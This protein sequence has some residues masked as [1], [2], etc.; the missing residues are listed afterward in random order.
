M[1]DP[2]KIYTEAELAKMYDDEL[3]EIEARLEREK[4]LHVDISKEQEEMLKTV[5]KIRS[6]YD[7]SGRSLEKN[8]TWLDRTNSRLRG[9]SEIL[10]GVE[11]LIA[12]TFRI[13]SKLGEP[14][15]KADQAAY[16][17]G[18][19][20]GASSKAVEQLRD[21]TIKFGAAAHIG[22]NYNATIAEMINLQES[23]AKQVGRN[24]QL[25][26]T[27][28]ETL[29]ATSKIMGDKAIDFSKK[30]ENLGIG[31]ER[32]G[33][34]AAKMFN[35]ASK[36]GV[37][38]EKYSESVTANLTKVQSYGFRNGVEGLTAMA[39]K[40]AEVNLN[41]AEAFK[42]ADKIQTGGI[43]EAIKMGANL[44]VLGG[45]FA[46]MGDPM[47]MLYQGLNDVEGL[48]DRMVKMFSRLG[49]I[50][51]GQVKISAANRLRVN[52][53]AQAM[54]IS[55]DE[56]FNMISRQAVRGQV[57]KQMGGR[58]DNDEE[59]KEL[60]M[61]TA[62][63][64]KNNEA[65]VNINGQEKKLSEVSEKDKAYLKDL[66]KSES[67]DIKDIAQILRGYT[68][69]QSG[70]TK[71]VE[72]QKAQSFDFI[73]KGT[74]AIYQAI[75]TS[76]GFLKA[77]MVS[78]GILT[79][80]SAVSN[81]AGSIRNIGRGFGGLTGAGRAA[82]GTAG[83]TRAAS[84]TRSAKAADVI[85]HTRAE[86]V[87]AAK[88]LESRGYT[89]KNGKVFRPDGNLA[90]GNVANGMKVDPAKVLAREEAMVAKTTKAA[91]SATK[92]AETA[93]KTAGAVT[94]AGSAV[95]KAASVGG[96]VISKAGGAIAGGAFAALGYAL[97]GSW[98]GSRSNKNKAIGGTVGATIGGLASMIPV[99]GPIAGIAGAMAG[100]WVGEKIGGAITKMQD[101]KRAE[102]RR[103]GL[104]E[105]GKTT[106]EG[107]AFEALK[108]DYSS[109]ELKKIK[110]A[111]KDGTIEKGELSKSL[112][113]KLQKS[114]D[115]DL[116]ERFG[117]EEAKNKFK[118]AI[119]KMN[120]DIENG[121]MN[122]KNANVSFAN[123]NI[124]QSEPIAMASGGKLSGPSDINGPGMPIKGSNIVVGGGEYIVNAEATKKNEHLLDRINS[125]ETIK[126]AGGGILPKIN[127]IV[128][129]IM[130][131][132][133]APLSVSVA[134][135]ES[136]LGMHRD[137]VD[138]MEISPIKLDVSGTIKLDAG[139]KQVDLD[140]IMNNPAFLTQLSQMIERRLSDNI[141][142]GNFKELRKSK[143]HNF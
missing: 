54:G 58:F 70:F 142:G 105:L 22:E 65:V 72:N 7:K 106:D 103:T 120:A 108:G 90:R 115:E 23:Y 109:K 31:L 92:A 98:K 128:P 9:T 35:E 116:I 80:V 19:H 118:K 81:V 12:G 88:T 55:N 33:D 11:Q 6:E 20:I 137:N 15:G 59:L 133:M 45:S 8:S 140:A 119:G 89:F 139:G 127:N 138:K 69:K 113:R 38:F 37:S 126:M 93:G 53:A 110:D 122:I 49:Q 99:I 96:K 95:G 26:N 131:S 132:P 75:G 114:G 111:L 16:D 10:G 64:N 121:E 24:L 129:N 68:D 74:K 62:T 66:Q 104:A 4:R 97:D 36:S 13:V 125:G 107:K 40:A 27:Q 25:T 42:V 76:N 1:V 46:Q 134:A 2:D 5:K 48:Q 29:L 73:G 60:I 3:A 78:V 52:A 141:N 63:L 43:Q 79:A 135:A 41:I 51:N 123:A 117:D 18:K 32:S 87:S 14:W 34:L 100:Q 102:A 82:S 101:K 57:S 39:K 130:K 84:A 30:L 61:N 47:G 94:K 136:A 77:I 67:E 85:S 91:A 44:Q 17:F 56:M 112:M 83:A 143:Q 124:G 28:R 21:Q 71:E 50:E 86:R